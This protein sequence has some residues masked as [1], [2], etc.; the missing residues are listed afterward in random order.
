MPFTPEQLAAIQEKAQEDADWAH[1]NHEY[2]EAYDAAFNARLVQ[3]GADPTRLG[4]TPR[5]ERFRWRASLIF[6]TAEQAAAASLD[7]A[8]GS[9]ESPTSESPSPEI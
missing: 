1:W 4:S 5:H 2:D 9:P 3:W 8:S 7:R 6:S